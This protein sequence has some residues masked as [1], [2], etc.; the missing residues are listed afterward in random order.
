MENDE[1]E[2][3]LQK[4]FKRRHFV[5]LFCLLLGVTAIVIS[6]ALFRETIALP[7]SIIFAVGSFLFCCLKVYRC[8]RCNT[9]P[10]L[11]SVPTVSIFPS[12]CQKCGLRLLDVPEWLQS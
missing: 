12:R 2:R 6:A 3:F 1:K 11:R 9:V 7:L 10:R 4:E 8:P 5:F